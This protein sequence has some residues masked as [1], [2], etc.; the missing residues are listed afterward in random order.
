VNTIFWHCWLRNGGATPN[1]NSQDDITFFESQGVALKNIALGARVYQ[2][3][4]D[5][6][7][8]AAFGGPM[9]LS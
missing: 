8:E 5:R 7:V 6:G 1:R 3:T 4:L 9:A 2:K